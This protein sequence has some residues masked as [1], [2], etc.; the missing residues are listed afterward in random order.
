MIKPK[1]LFLCSENSCRT[2]MAEAFLRDMAGDRFEVMS[3]GAEATTLDPEAVAAMDEVGLDISRQT[4]KNVDQ[5]Q[6][7]RVAFLV[8][9]CDRELE[10]TC[11]IFPGA[12][13]RLQWP[14]ENPAS[15]RTREERR[16][17]T[18]RVRDEI[19]GHVL[20]FVQENA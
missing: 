9:L 17:M 13:W 1:V 2:Q 5:F 3:A 16:A 18:R 19:R 14:I 11:P 4:P 12:T 10:R 15:A 6:R 8:T 20:Q 7:E